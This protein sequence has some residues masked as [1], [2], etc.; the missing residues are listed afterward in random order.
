[1]AVKTANRLKELAGRGRLYEYF[2]DA[3]RLVPPYEVLRPMKLVL[4]SY[5]ESGSLQVGVR[6]ILGSEDVLYRAARM[7][8]SHPDY[9]LFV[10]Q[11]D[12]F[13]GKWEPINAVVRYQRDW[14]RLMNAVAMSVLSPGTA[15]AQLSQTVFA[16]M[17]LPARDMASGL[18][19]MMNPWGSGWRESKFVGATLT[20]SRE[21]TGIL[22]REIEDSMKVGRLADWVSA[23]VAPIAVKGTGVSAVDNFARGFSYLG[24]KSELT[25]LLEAHLAGN[26]GAT[27]RLIKA[28]FDRDLLVADGAARESLMQEVKYLSKE[29]A[30]KYNLRS[31][32]LSSPAYLS[33]PSLQVMRGLNMFAVNMTKLF[34][35]EFIRPGTVKN[36]EGLLD[37]VTMLSRAAGYG[38]VV[39]ILVNRFRNALYGRP[40]PQ[41]FW[42]EGFGALGAIGALGVFDRMLDIFT[43]RDGNFVGWENLPVRAAAAAGKMLVSLSGGAGPVIAGRHLMSLAKGKP[44]EVVPGYGRILQRGWEWL[45]GQQ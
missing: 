36:M 14:G 37:Y 27:R 21:L 11:L 40:Q 42:A 41:D 22:F 9:E 12:R 34:Y 39:G 28:G 7:F 45:T 33:E 2:E 32:V 17:K 23:K 44:L 3:S 20:D 26:A 1:M 19:K 8:E 5:L 15:A 16:A 25:R 10:N 13:L 4:A 35:K 6:R 31:D 30:D 24:R 38:T 29:F 43:D 18:M